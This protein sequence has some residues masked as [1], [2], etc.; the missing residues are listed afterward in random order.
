ML[1]DADQYHVTL[2]QETNLLPATDSGSRIN[3]L[4]IPG[5]W[6]LASP[7]TAVTPSNRGKGL[8]ILAHPLLTSQSCGDFIPDPIIQPVSECVCESFELMAAAI[9]GI[10]VVNI[11]VHASC[12]PDYDGLRTA[13]ESIP[14]VTDA[15]VIIGGDFNHPQ[16]R[17]VLE[18]EVMA[19]LGFSPAY[20]PDHPIHTRG[21]SALDLFF[22]KGPSID[23]SPMVASAGSTS[24]H[25]II[26]TEIRGTT[27]ASLVAP[28]APPVMIQWGNLP[29][30]PFHQL[31]DEEKKRYAPLVLACTESLAIS[32]QSR[33]PLSAMTD[34]LLEVA[35]QHL[36]T[37]EYRTKHRTPWW[38][39][40]LTRL[41]KQVRRAHKCTLRVRKSTRDQH[42]QHQRYKDLLA[43]YTR[44]CDKARRRCAESFQAKFC[45]T[46]MNRTW[47]ATDGHRGKRH[48]K[49]LRRTA[50]NPEVAA[51][52][53]AGVFS[54]PRFPPPPP[55]TPSPDTHQ[56]FSDSDVSSAMQDLNDTTPGEDGLRARLLKFF[57]G[58]SATAELIS[59][60]F[61]SACSSCISTQAK[62]SITIL[63]KKPRATGSD[64]SSYR[65]I[66]LQP[67]M[68]KL[69]SKCV[70]H[71]I[72]QQ[73][74]DGSVPLSDSQG[75]F[76]AHRSRYDLIT[77]LRCAQESYHSRDRRHSQGRQAYV[78]F[79]DIKKAYDTV[80]HSRIIS[81]LQD[82]GVSDDMIRVVQDLLTNR[83]TVIYGHTIQ[84]GRGVPQGDPLSPLL[85]ILYLQPLSEALAAL[86]G[87]G[88]SLPGDLCIKDLLYAD[89]A[90]IL[91]ETPEDLNRMLS[92][93]QQWAEENGFEFSVEKS[94]AM[95]L[96]GP[97]PSPFP[98]ILLY[99]QPLEWVSEFKYLGFPVFAS[100]KTPRFLPLDLTSVHRVVEPMKFILSPESSPELPVIQ[101]VQAL[102]SMVE[103]KAMH[104][105]Q[106]ADLDTKRIDQYINKGLR[107]ITGLIDSTFLR[108]DLGVLP[109]ELI[110]HR[111][112]MYYL[113][114]LR[115]RAWFHPYL[116]LL[117]HL[118]PIRR[119]TSI[120]LQY[121]DITMADIDW[122]DY[123][124]W[125]GAVKDA[126]LRRALTCYDVSRYSGYQLYP[127]PEY[128]F[129]Y[130]GQSYTNH[131]LTVNLAQAAVELRHDRLCGIPQYWEHHPCVHCHQPRGLNGRHL[132]QCPHLPSNLRAER[133][134][135]ISDYYPN[136][137]I[138]N[139]AAGVITCVGCE[140]TKEVGNNPLTEFW[141]KS[142]TLG[143]KI[144]R[145]TRKV[146]V[147][148]S[149][150]PSPSS[151]P[152]S[153]SDSQRPTTSPTAVARSGPVYAPPVCCLQNL[154]GA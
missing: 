94:K 57:T 131:P 135:L 7:S 3:H 141:C 2:L 86:E 54:E 85:F 143:R 124:Q 16:S 130:R 68:T 119:L 59:K 103:G 108:C 126:V 133:A 122:M 88:L 70:E 58:D 24:D 52:T 150:Q 42:Q 114:H 98:D 47:R 149:A 105:A 73:I 82:A 99:G 36:G 128:T 4:D 111:N 110:V 152:P 112:A 146:V 60:G 6:T 74:N 106:V 109:A 65:P 29:D 11:Y 118:P 63:I 51:Q 41:H 87:G 104:N 14:G 77:L 92:V 147:D 95:V 50:A 120:V 144:L 28:S 1:G 21:N 123:E 48:P 97:T 89:D 113:W 75:G 44:A 90:A 18:E 55:T 13:V 49:Y 66:A 31:P 107:R 19:P 43:K 79:L 72:L 78:A 142:V 138:A 132:L 53:W 134:Q 129:K 96:A 23:A 145:Y 9:A 84:I 15:N 83:T 39:K 151:N 5:D 102:C 140:D 121:H 45:P 64:P 38:N 148:S 61:N 25:L 62:K 30:V 125:R 22:W 20:D 116:P 69:L 93:C 26:S 34:S 91:A 27:L 32:C 117:A 127:S 76:R 153:P 46:D 35:A 67:V 100:S 10:I 81:R 154:E 12:Q 37:K 56:P 8:A 80:P 136:L 33:D 71:R 101:R 137:T 40:G 139:F 115:R 17:R